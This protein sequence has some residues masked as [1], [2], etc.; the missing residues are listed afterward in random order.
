MTMRNRNRISVPKREPVFTTTLISLTLVAANISV[1][2]QQANNQVTNDLETRLGR[3]ARGATI[4]RIWVRGVY[5]TL[6]VVSALVIGDYQIGMGVFPEGMDAGDF[7]DLASHEGNWMLHDSRTL[8]DTSSVTTFPILLVPANVE[9]GSAVN[10]DNRSQRKLERKG[11]D[12]WFV[13]QKSAA[14]EENIQFRG[15]VTVLWKLL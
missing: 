5:H 1:A 9:S 14:T 10:L 8:A 11:D 7:D 3:T 2:S 12:L 6:A 4:T 15:T 13:M